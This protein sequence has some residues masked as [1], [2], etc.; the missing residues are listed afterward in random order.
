MFVINTGS[1]KPWCSVLQVIII[2][3]CEPFAENTVSDTLKC[4]I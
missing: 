3:K 4:G 2:T 1:K